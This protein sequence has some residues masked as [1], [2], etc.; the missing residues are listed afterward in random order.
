MEEKVIYETKEFRI[1]D[2]KVENKKTTLPIKNI[3]GV[4]IDVLNPKYGALIFLLIMGLLH[5]LPFFVYGKPK[6][7]LD[8]LVLVVGLIMTL[9]CF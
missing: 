1:T 2:K 9:F 3:T 7:V 4:E 8:I 6:N 5:L